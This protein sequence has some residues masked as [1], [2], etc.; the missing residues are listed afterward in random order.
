VFEYYSRAGS[1]LTLSL[2]ITGALTT[3]VSLFYYLKVPLYAYLKDSQ[4]SQ[5]INAKTGFLTYIVLFLAFI[6]ILLGIFPDLI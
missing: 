1:I 4:V 5:T 3:V 6:L 2:L